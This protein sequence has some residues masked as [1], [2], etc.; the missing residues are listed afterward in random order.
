MPVPF[1]LGD[2]GRGPALAAGLYLGNKIDALMWADGN[3]II[4][5]NGGVEKKPGKELYFDNGSVVTALAQARVSEFRKRE[6]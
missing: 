3:D 5:R 1:K 6:I 2:V 4:F